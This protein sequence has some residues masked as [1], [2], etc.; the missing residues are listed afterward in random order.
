MATECSRPRKRG[1]SVTQNLPRGREI[2]TAKGNTK[3][4]SPAI[5]H[6][7]GEYDLRHAPV[8]RAGRFMRDHYV[9]LIEG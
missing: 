4:C 5:L 8:R 6:D 2:T 9:T 3:S 1:A 7:A